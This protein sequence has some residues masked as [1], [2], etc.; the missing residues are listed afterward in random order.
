[1]VK[2]FTR[3]E[4]RLPELVKDQLKA[5]CG[6]LTPKN[7]VV[8]PNWVV[9]EDDP[10][11]PIKAL[12]TDSRLIDVVVRAC[13]EVFPDCEKITVADCPLQSADWP[14]MCEQ[15]GLKEVIQCLENDFGSRVRFLDLRKDV[16]SL[17]GG[18]K[19]IR[20]TDDQYGDPLGYSEIDLN[21]KSHLEPISEQSELFSL[22]D[23]KATV[24]RQH[25]RPG[26]HQYFVGRTYLSA[27]LFINLPKWK[28]HS[29]TALTGALKNLVGINGDKAYLPHYRRGCPRWGGDEYNDSD[30]WLMWVKT[31]IH[32]LVF[33]R[34]TIL[35]LTLRPCWL[36]IKFVHK[37]LR[38]N[39]LDNKQS[40][41]VSGG[42]WYGN[43][44]IWRMIYDLNFVIQ[45]CD[46]DG[47]LRP[48]P[49]RAYFCVVDGLVAGEGEGPLKPQPRHLNCVAF[50]DDPFEVDAVLASF[51]GFDTK[52]MPIISCRREY[53]GCN[54][55]K[56]DE[57]KLAAC[58]DGKSV[59]VQA[60]GP[61]YSFKPP[62]GWLNHIERSLNATG[63][64]G[65]KSTSTKSDNSFSDLLR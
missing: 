64:F 22:A 3:A 15:S 30:R 38:R 52:R 35:Y 43:Q 13:L 26:S 61:N 42:G 47:I 25:H 14:L 17:V 54:W 63:V 6:T 19:Y 29:K 56:F 28:T 53:L 50:G 57:E 32:Q 20:N 9:H 36:A 11:Y 59:F 12:I 16:V 2:F 31:F 4:A 37:C 40:L 58:V 48:E 34:S 55:G 45:H 60:D 62:A 5:S 10:L 51:M 1:M 44:T 65:N 41:Y 33:R 27:D 46:K 24:T 21:G 8:K 18:H 23:Y 39:G 7:I 49:Q